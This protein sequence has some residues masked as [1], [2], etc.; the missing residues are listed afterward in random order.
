MKPAHSEFWT[1]FENL[2]YQRNEKNNDFN[3]FDS[4]FRKV[5]QNGN[6]LNTIK[7]QILRSSMKV[8]KS[9]YFNFLKNFKLINLKCKKPLNFLFPMFLIE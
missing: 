7:D 2:G 6:N 5:V 9:H 1:R 3:Y 8:T 4:Y